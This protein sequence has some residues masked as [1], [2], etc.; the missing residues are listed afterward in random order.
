[1]LLPA[2]ASGLARYR[3][4]SIMSSDTSTG[5]RFDAIFP[6]V[7]PFCTLYC[8]AAAPPSDAAG[9]ACLRA[10]A[11]SAP[12]ADC[13]DGA[14]V[15]RVVAA[16]WGA[17][18]VRE[19]CESTSTGAAT[20]GAW[21]LRMSAGSSKNV[22]SRT[23]LPLLQLSSSS[24]STNGSLTGCVDVILTY[25]RDPRCSTA[26]RSDS[27][28]GLN[29]MLATRKAST[30]ASLATKPFASSAETAVSS[31]SAIKGCPRPDITVSLPRPAAKA[32]EDR[33]TALAT[34]P[35]SVFS[36]NEVILERVFKCIVGGIRVDWR[37]S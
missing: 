12:G 35:D 36:A 22:Y 29:S 31:I 6:S 10:G 11:E 25:W 28:A 19:P 8:D 5:F 15:R 30:G 9:A 7:S 13:A 26:N 21:V 14:G 34:A 1:M 16:P 2:N 24:M 33:I 20:C 23:S 32:D 4:T 27:S 37:E 17:G 18:V 3:A